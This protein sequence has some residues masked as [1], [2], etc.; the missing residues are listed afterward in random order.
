MRPDYDF[1][2]GVR[3]VTAARFAEGTNLVVVDLAILDVFP[4]CQPVNEALRALA[5]VIRRGRG[6]RSA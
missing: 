3:C 4:D 6:Q 1:S 5:E 2:G